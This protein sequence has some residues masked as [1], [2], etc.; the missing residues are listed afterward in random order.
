MKK[1][2]GWIYDL[3]LG[4][5]VYVV[6]S[7]SRSR[8]RE[9]AKV[10]TVGTKY[11]HFTPVFENGTLAPDH[12]RF[13]ALRHQHYFPPSTEASTGTGDTLFPSEA[14]YDAYVMQVRK[15][16]DIRDCLTSTYERVTAE[17]VNAVYDILFP[18]GE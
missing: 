5:T 13:K 8:R 17:Q 18:E 14:A 16:R 11:V 9:I 1:P 12:M 3:K 7:D 6:A 4:D 10:T 15:L 2:N